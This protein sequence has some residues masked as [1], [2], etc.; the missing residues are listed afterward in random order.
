[1]FEHRALQER[2]V[3]IYARAETLVPGDRLVHV[4]GLG[5][6][7]EVSARILDAVLEAVPSLRKH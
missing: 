5:K 6:P 4:S 7:E 1:M 2:L 3:A